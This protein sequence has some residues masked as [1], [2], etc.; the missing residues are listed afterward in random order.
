MDT[1]LEGIVLREVLSTEEIFFCEKTFVEEIRRKINENLKFYFL[2]KDCS[3]QI[4]LQ[5]FVY[6][7]QFFE[8]FCIC[9]SPNPKNFYIRLTKGQNEK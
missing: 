9:N 1:V 4:K 7:P 8:H 6:L 3:F 5:L 2:A